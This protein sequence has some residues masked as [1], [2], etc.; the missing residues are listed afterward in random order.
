[1]STK[2]KRNEEEVKLDTSV[3][4]NYSPELDSSIW[5]N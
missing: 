1:M 3:V 2:T 4:D 5:Y